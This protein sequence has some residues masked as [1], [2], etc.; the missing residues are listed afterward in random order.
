MAVSINRFLD[1]PNEQTRQHIVD[2]F[3]THKVLDIAECG[4]DRMTELRLLYQE[5]LKTSARFVRFFEM[6]NVHNR[7]IYY[8][9]FATNHPLGHKKMKE[10]FWK[11]DS[12]SG[13]CFSDATDP[14]QPVLFEMDE[15]PKLA[16]ELHAHFVNRTVYVKTIEKFVDDC[17]PFIR[18]HMTKALKSLEQDGKIKVD[19]VKRDG[20]KRRKSTYPND[21]MIEFVAT[22][23]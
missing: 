23:F 11:V 16:R 15:S 9:F 20:T 13:F 6:K 19:T 21:A 10:A 4:K 7:I 1:H 5:Q 22:L 2:L 14:N 18:R 17:T 12:S 8:L 3:G